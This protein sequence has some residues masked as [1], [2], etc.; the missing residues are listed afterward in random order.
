VYVY[1]SRHL[2]NGIEV[3]QSKAILKQLYMQ[4]PVGEYVI[5]WLLLVNQQV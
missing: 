3:I 5:H 4:H 1:I 2:G